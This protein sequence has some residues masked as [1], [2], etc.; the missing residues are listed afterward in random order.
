MVIRTAVPTHR[1]D[2]KIRFD[3]VFPIIQICKPLAHHFSRIA[4]F[5]QIFHFL[6]SQQFQLL[7]VLLVTIRHLIRS[8][9]PD[10]I[11]FNNQFVG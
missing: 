3:R 2:K 1:S 5:F 4:G 6:K 8:K 9:V 7:N 10:D 11:D